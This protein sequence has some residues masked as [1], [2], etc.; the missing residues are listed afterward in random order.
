[1]MPDQPEQSPPTSSTAVEPAPP[2]GGSD[3]PAVD[4]Y[5]LQTAEPREHFACR[6]AERALREGRRIYI[7]AEDRDAAESMDE[8]L[9]SFS[10]GSFLPHALAGDAVTEDEPIA[11]GWD[12]APAA[13]ENARGYLIN[14]ALK[15]PGFAE[16]FEFVAEVVPTAES[17]SDETIKALRGTFASY[18]QQGYERH[19]KDDHP[20]VKRVRLHKP[21]HQKAAAER[22][23]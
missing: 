8:L 9:W 21:M 1:M 23:G 5:I 12:D 15:A 17:A 7:H 19:S 22:D 11:I 2:Q 4:F 6:L 20:Q 10:P 13:T 14:L 18:E 3:F 16:R